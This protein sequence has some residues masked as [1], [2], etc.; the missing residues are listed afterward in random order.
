MTGTML[1][2]SIGFRVRAE[3]RGEVVSTLEMLVERMCRAA[4]CVRARVLVDVA[5]PSALVWCAEWSD[6][7]SADAYF[8]S[9][10]FQVFRGL[11][12]LLRDEPYLV[13]DQIHGRCT[14]PIGQASSGLSRPHDAQLRDAAAQGAGLEAEDRGRPAHAFE[15][16]VSGFEHRLNVSPLDIGERRP[17]G[18]QRR[19]RHPGV[20]QRE[21]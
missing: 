7:P 13:L 9:R 11:R 6:R 8:G 15:S 20:L 18:P 16:P 14:T 10:D 5:D 3:K 17:S 1:N 19:L 21:R 12:I 4:G 2:S